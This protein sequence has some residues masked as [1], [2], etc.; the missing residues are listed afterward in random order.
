[1][2]HISHRDS[3]ADLVRVARDS[4]RSDMHEQ[5]QCSVTNMHQ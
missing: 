5:Q 3:V 2:V 1:V 4:M